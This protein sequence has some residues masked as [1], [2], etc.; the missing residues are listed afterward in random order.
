MKRVLPLILIGV[1][2]ALQQLAAQGGYGMGG[3]GYAPPSHPPSTSYP[4]GTANAATKSSGP[5]HVSVTV[6]AEEKG[7]P[8]TTFPTKTP[9]LYGS[10]TSTNTDKGERIHAVWVN[11]AT[12][13]ALYKTDM[14]SAQPN[15]NGTV[16]INA[17]PTGFPAGKYELDIYLANKM[18]ARAPFNVKGSGN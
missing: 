10:F 7:N 15:F 14:V 9:H 2:A 12:K 16:S 4:A 11:T 5:A 17:P 3:G 6:A 13:K 8:A 18:V 1:F